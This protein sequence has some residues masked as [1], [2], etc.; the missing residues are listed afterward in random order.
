MRP[1]W[2]REDGLVALVEEPG[3]WTFVS[4]EGKLRC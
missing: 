1:G 3:A 2:G 4:G